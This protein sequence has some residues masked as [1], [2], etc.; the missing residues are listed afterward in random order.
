MSLTDSYKIV[1]STTA[2]GLS[3]QVNQHIEDGWIPT[4]GVQQTPGQT[5]IQAV[6]RNKVVAV[7]TVV[8]VRSEGW[9]YILAVVIGS[10]FGF[11]G[12]LVI[13]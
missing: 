10:L 7:E 4:G 11:L 12:S 8:H 3:R 13:A 6:V 5:Y 9:Q 2:T 1:A